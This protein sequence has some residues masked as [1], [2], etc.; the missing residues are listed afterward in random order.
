MVVHAYHPSV[1]GG[2]GVGEGSGAQGH[3]QM[4]SKF[5]V[6]VIIRD[7]IRKEIEKKGRWGGGGKWGRERKGFPVAGTFCWL[8]MSALY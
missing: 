6:S 7:C 1:Q 8:K 5:V 3:S 2:C 4:H